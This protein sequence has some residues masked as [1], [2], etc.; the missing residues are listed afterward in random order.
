MSAVGANTFRTDIQG[1]RAIAVGAVLVYHVWPAWLPGGYVGVDV[2]FV[3]SGY[4]ITGLLVREL[5]RS[6]TVGLR[7]FY[8]R[9]IRRLLPASAATLFAVAAA[10]VAWMSVADWRGVVAELL[11]SAFYVQNLLL[12]GQQVDYLAL[13]A[14]PS[15]LIHF[16]SLSVE[17][18]FYIFWPLLMVAMAALA[19]R[20]G[21]ELRRT[22]LA[23]LGIVCALSLGHSIHLSFVDPAPGYFIT[24]TRVW[25]LG[26]GGLLAIAKPGVGVARPLR[27]AL[28]WAGL[29]AI[30][31]SAYFYS[32]RLPFPGYE[33]L[34][35][36][37]GAAALLYACLDRSDP[38]GRW[39]ATA[40]M[41]YVGAISYSLYLWH[42]P[43]VVF[44]PSVTGRQ[45]DTLQDG[46]LVVVVSV[47]CAHLCRELIEER[48]RRS[49][50]L[51]V[52][53][54][55]AIAGALA[56]SIAAVS[57]LISMEAENRTQTALGEMV[58]TS[59]HAGAMSIAHGQP[60]ELES[61]DF[62]PSADVARLDRGV[63]YD[64]DGRTV[65]VAT[66]RS[67]EVASC[68]YGDVGGTERV[69]IVGD[70]HAVHWLPAMKIIAESANWHVSGITKS[71]CVFTDELIGHSASGV[72]RDYN[73]CKI[74][75][76]KVLQ[77][78]LRERPDLVI[79]SHSA[80]HVLPG[81]RSGE[82]GEAIARGILRH[83]SVLHEAGITVA[84]IVHTP[85]QHQDV[86]RCM[87]LSNAT[88]DLCSA[89]EDTAVHRGTIT[90]VLAMDPSIGAIDMLPYF[91]QAGTCPVVIGGVLVY[92]D[93]HHLTATYAKTLAPI[94]EQRIR[95]L[96]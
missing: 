30:V 61:G 1:M 18:Q 45:V 58:A 55:Y 66:V 14:A 67:E 46:V 17:E 38:L 52:F 70:S 76:D 6:G 34:L 63:A 26:I 87:A 37:L 83:A 90:P 69:V 74:W 42:W 8:A 19:S 11:A 54:P 53:R 32:H 75:G 86:P 64:H 9:R 96:L 73:E 44:Y 57:L 71:N 47:L 60:G 94:L 39:L 68:D 22:L 84:A 15:P 85:W 51:E 25:E 93:R 33:A 91:C 12:A 72:S 40:P 4:L 80:M 56:L 65:C 78:L 89:P 50:P 41:Q 2:F 79:L 95:E 31:T 81:G 88:V 48:F 36:T 10:T 82:D 35:P 16:W 3:I 21:W 5:E 20:K 43:V 59:E 13:D 24:T 29:L 92:R 62:I 28:A 27:L 77:R 23:S 7:G 49:R